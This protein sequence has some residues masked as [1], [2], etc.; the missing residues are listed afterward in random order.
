[1]HPAQGRIITASRMG[2][3]KKK[4]KKIER[5]QDRMRLSGTAVLHAD[6]LADWRR[7]GPEHGIRKFGWFSVQ[8]A[9]EGC[10]VKVPLL[11]TLP[12]GSFATAMGLKFYCR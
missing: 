7:Q 9:L 3:D 4:K 1:M 8:S 11:G 12:T 5:V 10:R 2:Y 6:C